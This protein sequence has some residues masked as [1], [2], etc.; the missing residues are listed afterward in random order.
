MN[1]KIKWLVVGVVIAATWSVVADDVFVSHRGGSGIRESWFSVGH[2][3]DG[4][5]LYAK[6]A[7]QLHEKMYEGYWESAAALT[8]STRFVMI[9]MSNTVDFPHR[10]TVT[11]STHL[12]VDYVDF[13]MC[14]S[15][16][17]GN[18][19]ARVGVV[20]A[21]DGDSG[22]M[23][24]IWGTAVTVNRDC[25]QDRTPPLHK[26]LELEG[27]TL[28]YV[29][30]NITINDEDFATDG[31]VEDFAGNTI[32]PGIGDL[33]LDLEEVS[34]NGDLDVF[35]TISYTSETY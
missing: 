6:G 4:G 11:A 13:K 28:E 19:L 3:S 10:G 27:T 31:S 5:S 24:V 14:L 23:D 8:G 12:S 21:Q 16:N 25:Q 32:V 17:S 20:T 1:E 33:I 18:W 2:A 29:M 7:V 35:V 9:D 15:T 34:G 26:V 30:S 22:D